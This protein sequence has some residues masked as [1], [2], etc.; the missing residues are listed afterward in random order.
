VDFEFDDDQLDL[1][2]AAAEIL[3]KECPASY[4]RSVVADGHDPTDLWSNLVALDWPG[5]AIPADSGGVGASAIELAI[6]LEQLGYVGDPTPFLATT[7]QFVPV[8]A[9]CSNAEQHRRFLGPVATEGQ[10]EPWPSPHRRGPT[11]R[12]T[13]DRRRSSPDGAAISGSC[14]AR[15]PS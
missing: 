2:A 4:L 14:T 3:A 9:Q 11:R 5:L 8:I 15:R 6:V 1:Q 10:W 12:G 7:S 13:R